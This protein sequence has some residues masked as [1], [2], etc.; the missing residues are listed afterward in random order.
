ME[1]I[2]VTPYSTLPHHTQ[3]QKINSECIIYLNIKDT[4]I[5]LLEE[6]I[7]KYL[8][9]PE[10]AKY[11]LNRAQKLLITKEMTDNLTTLKFGSS[12]YGKTRHRL[13]DLRV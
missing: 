13:G 5:N 12:T 7:D 8:R 11:F 9:D 2:M 10:V 4:A 6:N 1:K 3:Y